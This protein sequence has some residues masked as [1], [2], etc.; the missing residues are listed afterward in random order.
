MRVPFPVASVTRVP[1]EEEKEDFLSSVSK[2][3]KPSPTSHVLSS[4][5][6]SPR[7]PFLPLLYLLLTQLVLGEAIL[8]EEL[9]FCVPWGS[10]I[11]EVQAWLCPRLLFTK[12]LGT[13]KLRINPT[14]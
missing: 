5:S 6:C 12:A 1:T 10:L 14:P 4:S 7:L 8:G 9:R 2:T 13:E 3:A 11:P